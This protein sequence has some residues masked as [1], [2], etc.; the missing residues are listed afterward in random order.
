MLPTPRIPE[1]GSPAAGPGAQNGLDILEVPI[2]VGA[3]SSAPS[4]QLP[5]EVTVVEVEDGVEVVIGG[6]PDPSAPVAF[7]ANLANFMSAGDLASV[8]L[9]LKQDV[10]NDLLTRADWERTI[11]SGLDYLGINYENRM[12]PWPGACGVYHPVL[13]EAI[14][15]FQSNAIMEIFP[16]GG[17]VKAALV[18]PAN[19]EKERQAWRVAE[20]LNYLLTKKLPGYRAD[21]EQLLF[22]LA[23]CGSAF[24]KVYPD[25]YTGVPTPVFVPAKDFVAP[26]GTTSLQDAPRYTHITRMDINEIRK[27]QTTDPVDPY[28]RNTQVLETIVSGQDTISEKQLSLKGLEN[29]DIGKNPVELYEC[30]VNLDLPG[31]E[32][33][34]GIARPYIVTLVRDTGEVL[35]IRRNWEEGDPLKRK[36]VHFVAY[37][38]IPGLGGIYGLG[39]IHLIGGLARGATSIL[40]QL[41]D[42]GTLA[43]LPSGFKTR[44]MRV[45]GGDD[46]PFAPGEWRDTDTPSGDLAKAIFPLPYKEPSTV[47]ATLLGGLVEEARQTAS[48]ADLKIKDVSASAPVGTTLA[49]F[50]RAFKV[51]SAIQA[52]LHAS[53]GQEFSLVAEIIRRSGAGEYEWDLPPAE[54]G[55]RGKDYDARI[56]VVPVSDPN[57]ATMAYRVMQYQ[58]ALQLAAQAPQIYDLPELH[59]GMLSALGMRDADKIVPRKGQGP[60]LDPVSENQRML[61]NQPVKAYQDQDHDAHITVHLMLVGDESV[62]KVMGQSPLSGAFQSSVYAH[63]AEHIGMKFR[64]D[65]ER[66]LGFPLPP[67]EAAGIQDIEEPLSKAIADAVGRLKQEVSRKESQEKAEQAAQ[68]P[69]IQIQLQELEIK[70]MAAQAQLIKIQGQLAVEREKLAGSQMETEAKIASQERIAQLTAE[71]DVLIAQMKEMQNAGKNSPGIPQ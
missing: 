65:V 44:S 21:T 50:E 23:F 33:P 31:F 38:Y 5:P 25:P 30:H 10:E 16:P 12:D 62:A 54:K 3:A 34:D 43:N 56:D 7:D 53:L 69:L 1:Q 67:Q 49:I 41:V 20:D 60:R 57:A 29:V 14:L 6:G 40:R 58:A 13:L 24:R 36:L 64:A 59:R 9:A 4:V 35:R 26:Y 8:G 22:D 71:V 32:D 37:Y 70:K 27:L 61:V 17:P 52:R 15:S 19:P 63:I 45:K 55:L 39:L 66:H 28:F 42:A 68:D 47:L 48:I 51:M 2:S 18:G 46:R 11:S